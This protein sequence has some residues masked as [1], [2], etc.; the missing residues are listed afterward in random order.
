MTQIDVDFKATHNWQVNHDGSAPAMER[1]GTLNIFKR[2][3]NTRKLQYVNFFGDGDTKSFSAV[4]HIYPGK[5]VKKFE[6]GA[7]S[8]KIWKKAPHTQKKL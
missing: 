3:S 4:E 8:E 6:C 7:C 5:T 2:S 1:D